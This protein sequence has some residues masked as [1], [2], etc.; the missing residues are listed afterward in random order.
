MVYSVPFDGGLEGI[1]DQSIIGNSLTYTLSFQPLGNR[2]YGE[3][4]ALCPCWQL[5]GNFTYVGANGV[6]TAPFDASIT[7][8]TGQIQ[9][10]QL[11]SYSVPT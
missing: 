3:A 10:M 1:S 7:A 4:G 11:G 5:N 2:T 6:A 8:D 9:K